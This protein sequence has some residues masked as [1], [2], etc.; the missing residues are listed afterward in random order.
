MIN[1]SD[2][3]IVELLLRKAFPLLPLPE[4]ATPDPDDRHERP[5]FLGKNWWEVELAEAT[6]QSYFTFGF[7]RAEAV[8][9]CPLMLLACLHDGGV[10]HDDYLERFFFPLEATTGAGSPDYFPRV[11]QRMNDDIH[12]IRETFDLPQRRAIAC[13]FSFLAGLGD[14]AAIEVLKSYWGRYLDAQ[15]SSSCQ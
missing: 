1:C 13:F 7:T 14:D 5:R 10:G 2:P 4:G 11:T 15:S 3:T 12:A 9:Y 6:K 8:Y